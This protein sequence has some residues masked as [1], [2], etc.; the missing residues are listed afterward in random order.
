MSSTLNVMNDA[1]FINK[2]T[3]QNITLGTG[4]GDIS[5][6]VGV[7]YQALTT[8]TTGYGNTSNGYNA[9]VT[10]TA[11]YYNTA[12]GYN[13]GYNNTTGGYNTFLGT[14]TDISPTTATWTESTAIG[15]NAKITASNQIV[16]GKSDT[17]VHVPY[18]MG[19]GTTSPDFPLEVEGS[20]ISDFDYDKYISET[21]IDN[22][23]WAGASSGIYT[24]VSSDRAVGIHASNAIGCNYIIFHSDR[25]IKKNIVDVPDN[26]A[27]QQVRD[28]PC[29]YY[30]YIDN[31]T[32]GSRN[33]VGFIAQEVNEVLPT[34][35]T[36]IKKCI[37]NEYRPLENISWEE[38]N[39]ISSN[40][41]Y[42]LSSDLTDVSGVKYRFIVANNVSNDKITEIDVV[43]NSDNTFTFD[44]SYQNVFCY[45][46]EVDDFHTIDKNQIF[47][48]HHSAIQEIDRLQLE[49]KEKTT[50]LETKNAELQT[51]N[52]ALETKNAELQTQIDNIMTILNNN[53]LS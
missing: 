23:P 24:N 38:I 14:S 47:A 5:T 29:R 12:T 26:L 7:G 36:K 16:L 20:V 48:L 51:K 43:G 19:V 52:T 42:K 10:N 11:G 34:S 50:A 30:Q 17:K 41:T 35:I 28:I 15:Y 18:R 8:N 4:N 45:G 37:P 1:T 49:E 31:A 13:A 33:V 46:K 9:L 32:K 2:I 21:T 25:R 39:D 44:V 53:N 40:I 22:R 6:N 27:L 3:V